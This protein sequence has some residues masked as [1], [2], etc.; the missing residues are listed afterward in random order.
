[1]NR[2][3]VSFLF[4]IFFFLLATAA[5]GF[6]PEDDIETVTRPDL[7]QANYYLSVPNQASCPFSVIVASEEYQAYL[8]NRGHLSFLQSTGASRSNLPDIIADADD[9]RRRDYQPNTRI[10]MRS[11]GHGDQDTHLGHVADSEEE[12]GN[13]IDAAALRRWVKRSPRPAISND[14]ETRE[15]FLQLLNLLKVNSLPPFLLAQGDLI[16][17]SSTRLAYRLSYNPRRQLVRDRGNLDEMRG[18][19]Y[20]RKGVFWGAEINKWEL[21][22][23]EA[24]LLASP[25]LTHLKIRVDF[26]DLEEIFRS[27]VL[28]R[29][30]SLELEIYSVPSDDF[31]Y[32]ED[33]RERIARRPLAS[34][35]N[36]R[37][38]SI[39]NTSSAPD[40]GSETPLH[41]FASAINLE[42]LRLNRVE[43]A[44]AEIPTMLGKL[45]TLEIVDGFQFVHTNRA[46]TRNFFN[47]I[48][49]KLKSFRWRESSWAFSEQVGDLLALGPH[50]TELEILD[51]HGVFPT[52]T[53][54]RNLSQT[55]HLWE[56]LTSFS[57]HEVEPIRISSGNDDSERLAGFRNLN[58]ALRSANRLQNLNLQVRFDG[59]EARI[60]FADVAARPKV[61]DLG[62]A[63][64]SRESITSLVREASLSE[65]EELDLRSSDP[66]ALPIFLDPNLA[67]LKRLY[68]GFEGGSHG[69]ALSS[70]FFTAMARFQER[71]VEV[72]WV[73]GATWRDVE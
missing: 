6:V 68:V 21:A 67:R 25:T 58:R 49:P 59:T 45:K 28:S 16:A 30:T 11:M 7:A 10:L 12:N 66:R 46:Q 44:T 19:V 48:N 57:Y 33:S 65:V 43:L 31:D 62:L 53:Q 29:L 54:W 64:L 72:C 56:K 9:F 20:F 32:R 63:R 34:L 52:E 4:G 14:D 18:D 17:S 13:E 24:D 5:P 36:L 15:R 1:M 51:L 61:I 38:L 41:Y 2:R 69:T 3:R 35:A 40:L 23:Q 71:G 37:H 60:L 22:A 55:R 8:E 47:G 39:T 27:P 42:S 50:F 70:D 26:W 73:S